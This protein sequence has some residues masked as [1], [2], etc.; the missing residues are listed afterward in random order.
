[1]A[2]SS[3]RWDQL[4]DDFV[5]SVSHELRFSLAAIAGYAELLRSKPLE[6]SSDKRDKALSI[7]QESTKPT[8]T[9]L[10]TTFSIWQ[11]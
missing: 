6:P 7:I 3:R 5:S 9:F 4:K 11:N 1:M 8:H 2:A 10:S